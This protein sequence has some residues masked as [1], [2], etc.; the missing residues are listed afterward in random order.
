[1]NDNPLL[2]YLYTEHNVSYLVLVTSSGGSLIKGTV[3]PV[4]GCMFLNNNPLFSLHFQWLLK[5]DILAHDI[6]VSV[7]LPPHIK[8]AIF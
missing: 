6:M 1:M 8:M 5:S 7:S 2:L 3:V 4:K